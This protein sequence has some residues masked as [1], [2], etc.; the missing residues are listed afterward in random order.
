MFKGPI[1]L[2]L[3]LIECVLKSLSITHAV[4]PFTPHA[5]TETHCVPEGAGEAVQGP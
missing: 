1:L 4:L 2:V 5:Y 3:D